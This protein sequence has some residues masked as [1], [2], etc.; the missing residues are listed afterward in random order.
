MNKK[1]NKNETKNSNTN[2][3]NISV[4]KKVIEQSIDSQID[5]DAIDE[6][7]VDLIFLLLAPQGA[8]ADHLKALARIARLFRDAGF[9]R[10]LLDAQTTQ[11]LFELIAQEDARH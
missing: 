9:K 10:R 3:D 4:E 6:R 1:E 5:F 2:F 11:E 7:P 8:G